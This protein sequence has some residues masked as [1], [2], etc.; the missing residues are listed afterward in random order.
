MLVLLALVVVVALAVAGLAGVGVLSA[1]RRA[2]RSGLLALLSA[3]AVL[4]VAVVLAAVAVLGVGGGRSGPEQPSSPAGTGAA[5]AGAAR[6]EPAPQVSL[7]PA[8]V[9]APA[10]DLP[11]VTIEAAG[12]AQF[13]THRPVGGLAPGGVVRVEAVGFEPFERGAVEQCVVELG[14][15]TACGAP[16]P[17]QFDGSGRSEFQYSLAAVGPGGCRTGQ[18]SCLLQV[19]GEVSGRRGAVPT[20]LV[21]PALAGRVTVT[22]DGDLVDGQTVVVEVTGF[23]PGS[24]A[25]AVLCAPP[26]HYDGRRCGPAAAAS[27]FTVDGRGAGRTVLTV[28]TGSLGAGDARCGPRHPCAVVAVVGSGYLAAPAAPVGF[29]VGPGVDY[30]AGRL[31]AGLALAVVLLAIAALVAVRTD[32]GAPAEADAPELDA[33]DLQV[34]ADLDELFGTDQE[35]DERDPVPW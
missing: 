12:D 27:S 30:A 25:T 35:L 9:V 1:E 32:W 22:P 8:R 11:R 14:R 21:D 26:G 19:R 31:L 18:P 34:D 28:A 13:P 17:V 16:F 3:P 29:S 5:G 20:V 10:A 2:D 24:E 15:Q 4:G 7:P 33:S 6:S 23:P